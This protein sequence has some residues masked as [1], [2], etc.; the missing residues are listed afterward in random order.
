MHSFTGD[1]RGQPWLKVHRRS[2]KMAGGGLDMEKG[3]IQNSLE[4]IQL[5][6][7]PQLSG[8]RRLLCLLETC[9]VNKG[10]ESDDAASRERDRR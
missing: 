9:W 1:M 8:Y 7:M 4:L 2:T 3:L 5:L 10:E 6:T